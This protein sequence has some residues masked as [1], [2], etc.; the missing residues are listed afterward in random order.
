MITEELQ[1]ALPE[2]YRVIREIGRGGMAI[3]YLA[4]DIPHEREVAVKVLSPQLGSAIDGERFKRE[5]R[6]AASSAT[7][8]F[9]PRT[10]REAHNGVLY[11][12]MP[13]VPGESLRERLDRA[14][15]SRSTR[16]SRS[17]A[18]WPMRS[19]TRTGRASCIA[20]SSPRT[21]CCR[22]DTPSSR[23][24]ASRV[25]VQDADS[26]RLTGTGMSIGT[27]TYMSPEQVA[28]VQLDGRS[29]M[30][31]LACV[32]YE[33]LAGSVPF[34][35]KSAMTI[36]ARHTMGQVPS[37]RI[38]RN[39]VPQELEDIILQ[40]L[41]KT[42]ADR[43]AS[44]GEFKAALLG[45]GGDTSTFKRTHA[46]LH[47]LVPCARRRNPADRGSLASGS[48]LPRP[49]R[50]CCSPPAF[51][52]RSHCGR[53]GPHSRATRLRTEWVCCISSTRAGMETCDISRTD[54]RSR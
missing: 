52:A 8:T 44:V 32:L 22:A 9:F 42:P 47:V 16:P 1:S 38:V 40:A 51:S 25:V 36:M 10:T 6:V 14:S 50:R 28:G 34:E 33:M 39:A 30:Y 49:S 11:Y 13:Y 12:V 37:I 17:R 18:T 45:G 19:S 20:T 27:P 26:D 29:D 31:S 41:E 46:R 24:S 53:R 21:S 4:E 35:G 2:R 48:R 5:I 23:T 3:V 43:F 15:S 7:R 54:S